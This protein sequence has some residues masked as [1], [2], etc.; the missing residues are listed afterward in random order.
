MGEV[1]KSFQTNYAGAEGGRRYPEDN[2]NNEHKENLSNHYL[3][4]NGYIN[5]NM[6]DP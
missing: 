5:F 2:V 4:V 3:T 1:F 6:L